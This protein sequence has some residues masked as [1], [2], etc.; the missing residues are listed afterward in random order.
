[1]HDR[2]KKVPTHKEKEKKYRIYLNDMPFD[3]ATMMTEVKAS[4]FIDE[5]RRL[6]GIMWL[7][8][9][10]VYFCTR[11]NEIFLTRQNI[12]PLHKIFVNLVLLRFI[13]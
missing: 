5:V 2:T 10:Y 3:E 12:F 13:R 8:N 6:A 9:P 11:P 1:M 7:G 4:Q